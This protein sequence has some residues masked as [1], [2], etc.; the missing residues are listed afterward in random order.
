MQ[1]ALALFTILA[2]VVTAAPAKDIHRTFPLDAAGRVVLENYKGTIQV[3]AWD[4]NEVS[5]DVRI[6]EDDAWFF[7]SQS[8]N[9]ADVRFDA[10]S[11]QLRIEGKTD[12]VPSFLSGAAPFFHYT[13]RMPRRASLR[14]KDYKSDT[15]ISGLESEI[16]METY[17]GSVRVRDLSGG[18]RLNTYKGTVRA[19]FQSL[20]K[21][22]TIDT[23][24][25]S[26]E[27]AIP[28][29]AGFDLRND[30]ER[31]ARLRSDFRTEGVVN[32]GGPALRLKSYKG[33]V[34][35]LAL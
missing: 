34:R 5:V 31:K 32:G 35:L 28:R 12:S 10:S 13:I 20:T 14:I 24:K 7:G 11:N 27:L 25:G 26:I 3:S 19:D 22:T 29:N 1:R 8:L 4:Q 23:Y 21:T 15:E 6:E 9:R 2:G 18:L 17:K 30:L 33:N 16:E